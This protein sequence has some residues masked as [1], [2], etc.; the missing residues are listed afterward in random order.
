MK[1]KKPKKQITKNTNIIDAL[2]I[3]PEAANV[4]MEAGMGCAGCA[5]AQFE[6]IEQGLKA[7]GFKQ[8]E[9]NEILKRLNK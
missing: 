8:K 7:H 4:L 2:E 6:T 1:T 3:N 5:M 9:I